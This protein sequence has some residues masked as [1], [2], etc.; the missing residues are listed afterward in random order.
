M[1]H[2][3]REGI[4]YWNYSFFEVCARDEKAPTDMDP[5]PWMHLFSDPSPDATTVIEHSFMPQMPTHGPSDVFVVKAHEAG[6]TVKYRVHCD[7]NATLA[8]LR[9]M[10][11]NDEDN[12]MSADDRF[13]QGNFRV[14]KSAEPH[15]KWRDALQVR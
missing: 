1:F 13:H 3:N 14:G 6:G 5:P 11:Q 12:M 15:I 2:T 4:D 8:V 10:L 9:N 7:P